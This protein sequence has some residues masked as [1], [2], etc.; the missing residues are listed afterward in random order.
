MA[1]LQ[2]LRDTPLLPRGDGG[3]SLESRPSSTCSSAESSPR[4]QIA[5]FM[6]LL[7]GKGHAQ[8]QLDNIVDM[9]DDVLLEWKLFNCPNSMYKAHRD[10]K[11]TRPASLKIYQPASHLIASRH[12]IM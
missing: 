4:G 12:S 11:D 5:S 2:G 6:H 8:S 9:I 10:V 3:G 7:E 1:A